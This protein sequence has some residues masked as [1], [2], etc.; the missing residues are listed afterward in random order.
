MRLGFRPKL[1]ADKMAESASAEEKRL[2]RT[3]TASLCRP[4]HFVFRIP[5]I[6]TKNDKIPV[7]RFPSAGRK[8]KG[9]VQRD[10][11]RLRPQ[12]KAGIAEKTAL[13]SILWPAG[14]VDAQPKLAFN[15]LIRQSGQS[16]T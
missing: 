14:V 4:Y 3:S 1:A 12:L 7:Q 2:N 16:T 9:G 5:S 6:T 8:E 10:S 15:L 13:L 11:G